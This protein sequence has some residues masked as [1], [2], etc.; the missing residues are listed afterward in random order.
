MLH[1][2][3]DLLTSLDD[4]QRHAGPK[5]PVQWQDGRSA[6][7]TARHWLAALPALPADVVAT[8]ASHPN[9]STVT[10]WSAEPEVQLRFDRRRGEPRN[11]DLLVLARDVHGPFLVAVEAKAD[12][13]F[14][15]MVAEAAADALERLT[16]NPRSGGVARLVDLVASLL[17]QATP[18]AAAVTELRYQ[19]LTAAAGVLA[20]AKAHHIARSVL[21]VQEFVTPRTTDSRHAANADD[22]DRFLHRLSG[23]HFSKA[24]HGELLGPIA[25]PG[26]P[27]FPDAP[28]LYVGKTRV[29]LRPA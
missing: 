18:G 14:G 15:Q 1:K 29:H 20:H 9:F 28:A 10:D 7:E 16:V 21:L 5:S 26:T 6:K 22:L 19:L 12:E 25:V 13:T 8:L 17:P 23:G 11:T 4:W 3:Q 24:A 2:S 27:L